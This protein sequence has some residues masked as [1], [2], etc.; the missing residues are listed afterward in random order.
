MLYQLYADRS[1]IVVVM[2]MTAIRTRE[3][4]CKRSRDHSSYY[5]SLQI[6]QHVIT[7]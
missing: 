6:C 5:L 3:A 2:V 1:T 7:H 4:G